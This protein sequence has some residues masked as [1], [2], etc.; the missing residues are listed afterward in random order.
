MA[1]VRD[2]DPELMYA[3]DVQIMADPGGVQLTF[4]R[5][6]P[7]GGDIGR[8]SPEHDATAEV[9]ARVVLPPLAARRLLRLL[10]RRLALQRELAEDYARATEAELEGDPF[11]AALAEA[12]DDDE[13][14]TDEQLV[15]AQAGWEEYQRGE[16]VSWEEFRPE[17]REEEGTS[18]VSAP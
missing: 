7:V 10:P 1:V 15:A 11:L 16:T 8:S 3:S 12:E 18:T 13:P 5:P 4:L 6:L 14:Y 17:L 2:D 9:I